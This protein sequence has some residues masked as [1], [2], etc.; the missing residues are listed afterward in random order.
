MRYSC[1]EWNPKR[2]HPDFSGIA[3]RYSGIKRERLSQQKKRKELESDH[4]YTLNLNQSLDKTLESRVQ[5][6]LKLQQARERHL[7][8]LRFVC[9]DPFRKNS[10]IKSV[11]SNCK[12]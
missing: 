2:F 12:V 6:L 11:G 5:E 7:N 9:I 3:T 4:C 1:Y 8:E 10:S